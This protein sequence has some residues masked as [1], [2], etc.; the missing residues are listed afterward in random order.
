[1]TLPGCDVSSY[2]GPPDDWRDAAGV[3]DWAAVKFSEVS[4]TGL[5]QNPDAAADWLTLRQRGKGRIAYAFAHPSA[6][7]TASAAAFAGMCDGLGLDAGDGIALD[8]E[9]T[10]GMTAA[11]VALWAQD[12]LRLMETSLGRRPLVYTDLSFGDSGACQG[13]G[14]WPLW[15]ADPSSP[16]GHPRLP[17]PWT[18]WAVHQWQIVGIDRDAAVY[19]SL[20]EMRALLGKPVPGGNVTEHTTGGALS[21]AGL[22]D[23]YKTDPSVILRL[24]ADHFP[25]GYPSPVA[26]DINDV[27]RGSVKVTD[28]MKPG[29]VLYLPG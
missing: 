17:W 25:D 18:S 28:P 8:L 2:Q 6:S 22:A 4:R 9:T 14:P 26:G 27:F 16:A 10:D 13:L 23:Q 21:L 20:A 5:Y 1:M 29:L 24:T 12:A 15:V 7:V 19:G 11:H 3:I